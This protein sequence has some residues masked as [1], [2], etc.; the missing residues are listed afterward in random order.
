MIMINQKLKLISKYSFST[1]KVPS[2][3]LHIFTNVV[4]FFSS[5]KSLCGN[6]GCQQKESTCAIELGESYFTVSTFLSFLLNTYKV[7]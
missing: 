2:K 4:R 7:L 3:Y 1:C 5:A 6:H